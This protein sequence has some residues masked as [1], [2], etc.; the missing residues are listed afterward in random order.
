LCALIFLYVGSGT[1]KKA[2]VITCLMW[3]ITYQ[4][5]KINQFGNCSN[6]HQVTE[7]FLYVLALLVRKVSIR[8]LLLALLEDQGQTNTPDPHPCIQQK[9]RKRKSQKMSEGT[10]P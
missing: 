2:G 10:N 6:L 4:R 9:K 8:L 5:E 3:V 7:F 1:T